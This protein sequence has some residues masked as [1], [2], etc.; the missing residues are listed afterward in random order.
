MARPSPPPSPPPPP[1]TAPVGCAPVVVAA[2]AAAAGGTGGAGTREG[3]GA[4]V[5]VWLLGL[6]GC[7]VRQEMKWPGRRGD[8]WSNHQRLE[9]LPPTEGIR[10]SWQGCTAD[11]HRHTN[12][13]ILPVCARPCWGGV[14]KCSTGV[15]RAPGHMIAGLATASLRRRPSDGSHSRPPRRRFRRGYAHG[16]RVVCAEPSTVQGQPGGGRRLS[17]RARCRTALYSS[18]APLVGGM[19]SRVVRSLQ[20][21]QH[22]LR[23]GEEGGGGSATTSHPPPP[24]LAI[25]RYPPP[26]TPRIR[27]ASPSTSASRGRPAGAPSGQAIMQRGGGSCGPLRAPTTAL[28][29]GRVQYQPAR[30]GTG[31]PTRELRKGLQTV[32]LPG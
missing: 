7:G 21:S 23:W 6:P 13:C 9:P 15:A 19:K 1:A 14:D 27:Q 17:N 26:T 18:P 12:L 29:G 20:S 4:G 22:P 11:M 30:P 32:I 10:A 3:R 28:G 16:S 2:E 25:T 5:R 8:L 24:T 31:H